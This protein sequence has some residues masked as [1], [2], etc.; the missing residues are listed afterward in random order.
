MNSIFYQFFIYTY[1][2]SVYMPFVEKK[3]NIGKEKKYLVAE[4]QGENKS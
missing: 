1:R 4:L 3:N 2:A